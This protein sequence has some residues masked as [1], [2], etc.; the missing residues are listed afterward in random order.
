MKARNAAVTTD[1]NRR[2]RTKNF[3]QYLCLS[4]LVSPLIRGPQL[5][6]AKKIFRK[7]LAY[8][9]FVGIIWLSLW[10]YAKRTN[11]TVYRDLKPYP[12]P[13]WAVYKDIIYWLAIS[14][15]FILLAWSMTNE[16]RAFTSKK[17]YFYFSRRLNVTSLTA[18]PFFMFGIVIGKSFDPIEQIVG[19]LSLLIF[20][21]LLIR[22]LAKWTLEFI[23]KAKQMIGSK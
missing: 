5:I 13:H 10:Q 19:T 8:Y 11:I 18:F 17:D 14:G 3:L 22:F 16:R 4:L 6:L 2:Q 21:A 7:L 12:E 23:S 1:N 20:V 15:F 9:F